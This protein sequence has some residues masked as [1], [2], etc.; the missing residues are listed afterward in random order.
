LSEE[1]RET[2]S[3]KMI[4]KFF[5]SIKI[6]DVGYKKIRLGNNRDGGYVVLDDISKKSKVLY[7]YGISDDISFEED[8]YKKYPNNKIRLFDHT[9]EKICTTNPNFYFV[10][11]GLA[12]EKTEELN[13][14]ENHINSFG[15]AEIKN[16]TLK[17]DIEWN[18]WNFFENINETTHRD[19]DQIL[20]EFHTIPVVYNGSHS[21]YFTGFH[22]QV[23]NQ[24]N[25]LMFERYFNIIEKI[26]KH[27]LP[28]HVHINNSLQPVNVNGF[29]VP[30][31]IELSLVN[32]NL[33]DT[34]SLSRDT[35]P[36]AGLD[37]PNKT[38]RPDYLNFKWNNE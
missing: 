31:L 18:E 21:P 20:C 7:S 29:D 38:D 1:R 2:Y 10:K 30:S 12:T 34:F 6:Y 13:T 17:I 28:F 26:K 23:Y 33:V 37:Y 32:K 8:F 3:I 16:K 24:M 35:Y 9:I 4:K 14:I 15:D 25:N 22:K 36:I 19:L 11:Q 5:D 27:Y